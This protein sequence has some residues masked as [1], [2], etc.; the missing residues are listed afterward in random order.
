MFS[1]PVCWVRKVEIEAG[2]GKTQYPKNQQS[3]YLCFFIFKEQILHKIINFMPFLN[4][5]KIAYISTFL[6]M[7]ILI[8]KTLN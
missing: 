6:I 8:Y 2:D 4:Y 1:N 5:I 3:I 7:L